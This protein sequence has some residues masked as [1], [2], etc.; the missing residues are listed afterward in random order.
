MTDRPAPVAAA[1]TGMPNLHPIP[2]ARLLR[3]EWRKS[4]DTRAARWLLA[5]VAVL[6]VGVLAVP[7]AV[8]SIDQ[9]FSGYAGIASLVLTILL[10]VVTILS[11]TAEWSQ[12]TAAVTFALEPRRLRVLMAKL[13]CAL[14]L[15][16]LGTAFLFGV[17][18]A[19]LAGSSLLGRAVGWNLGWE[20]VA[21]TTGFVVLNLAMA[22]AFGFLLQNSAASIVLYYLLPMVWGVLGAFSVFSTAGQWLNPA[23]TFGYVQAGQ[24]SGHWAEIGVSFGL[25]ILLPLVAGVIRTVRREVS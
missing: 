25:W 22:L 19:G 1:A 4:T 3:V 12:R 11:A 20:A 21:G 23:T 14:L 17:S 6:T 18:A 10:P 13:S 16:L 9:T 8:Q 24:W 2:F 7:L 5:L 15:S